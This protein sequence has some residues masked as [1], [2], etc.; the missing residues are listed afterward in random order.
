MSSTIGI[1]WRSKSAES[2]ISKLY[3]LI[4]QNPLGILTTNIPEHASADSSSPV[5]QSTFIPFIL[6]TPSPAESEAGKLGSLRALF[7]NSRKR[8]WMWRSRLRKSKANIRW[9]RRLRWGPV[10]DD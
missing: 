2:D 9:G 8:L 4:K 3:P 6:D 1:G 5:L 7:P 10:G